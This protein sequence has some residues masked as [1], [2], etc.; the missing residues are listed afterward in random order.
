MAEDRQGN[1][2]VATAA[3]QMPHEL[4]SIYRWVSNDVLGTP[5]ILDQDYLNE[6]KESGVIFGGGDLERRYRVVAARRTTPVE[7]GFRGPVSAASQLL[8]VYSLLR[9]VTEFLELPQ[10]PEVFLS[11]FKFYSSDTSGRTKKGYMSV[12]PTKNRK[13]F[14]LYEDSF[15]DFKGRYFNIFAVG[16]HRPF[17]L[18]LEGDGLFPPYWSDQAGFGIAPVKY[19]GLNA[20][21]RDTTDILTFLFSKNNLSSK[22]LLGSPEESRKAIARMA[23]NDVTL[24]RLRR[25]I[26]PAPS[27]SLQPSSAVPTGE[28]QRTPAT[29]AGKTQAEP[30][31]GSS[32]NVGTATEQFVEISS[33]VRV[34][35]PVPPSSSP[36]KRRSAVEDLPDP[37]RTQASEGGSR[38][39]CPLDRSF[40]A[41]GFIES[42]LLG[43]KAQ[44][45][46]RDCDPLESV[47]WAEWAIIRSATILRSVEL[48]WT[49]AY[50]VERRNAKLLGDAKL[51]GLQKVVLEEEKKEAVQGRLKAEEELR[52]LMAKFEALAREKEEEVGRLR[53][54]EEGLL[55]EP[56]RKSDLAEVS[57]SELQ[58]QCADLAED[59]KGAIAATEAA[60][61]AQL[62]IL[63]LEFDTDQSSF[64]KDIVDG[65]VVDPAD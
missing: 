36:R 51:L 16:D 58:G 17:L 52:V 20:D 42:H 43:P 64:F 54:R 37:K 27:Q 59:A 7:P 23:G 34:E 12:R 3:V 45:V 19:E 40:D 15:H 8:G 39:S 50:E 41:P 53:Q 28:S 44:E 25:L 46:L 5:S 31:G 6:L 21:K 35:V 14:T 30:D 47:R 10:E 1:Q 2:E 18:S 62:V 9:I 29:S 24:A 55:A 38:K 26:R 11:L 4:P 61:K 65:R 56:R 33:L 48:R 57:A 60:L 22:T 13:I 32:S 49:I 63:E